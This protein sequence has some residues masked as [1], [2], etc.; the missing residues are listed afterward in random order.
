MNS[1]RIWAPN[2]GLFFHARVKQLSA[3][4]S[5]RPFANALALMAQ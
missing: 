1:E 2:E 3:I 4:V 5:Y